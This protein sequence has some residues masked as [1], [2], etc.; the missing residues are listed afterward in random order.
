MDQKTSGNSTLSN[1]RMRINSEPTFEEPYIHNSFEGNFQVSMNSSFQIPHIQVERSPRDEVFPGLDS[2]PTSAQVLP[3]LHDDQVQGEY[4]TVLDMQTFPSDPIYDDA[5]GSAFPEYLE[6]IPD[7]PN[8]RQNVFSSNQTPGAQD[9]P[10]QQETPE[11]ENI[12]Q[13]LKDND[14]SEDGLL[15]RNVQSAVNELIETEENYVQWLSFLTADVQDSLNQ[16]PQ[17]DVKCLFSNLNEIVVLSSSFL[18]ELKKTENDKENQLRHIGK[19]FQAFSQDMQ[20]SYSFYCLNYPGILSLLRQYK[21][22]AVLPQIQKVLQSKARSSKMLE[23]SFLLVK[24]VQRITKYPLLIERMLKDV[25]S[26]HKSHEE[27]QKALNAM[28]DVNIN[29]N[30]NKRCRE[31]AS[32]YLHEDERSLRDRVAQINS[33]SLLKKSRRVGTMLKQEAGILPKREDKEFDTLVE[34]FQALTSIVNELKENILCYMKNTEVLMRFQLYATEQEFLQGPAQ[35]FQRLSLLLFHKIYPEFIRRLQI[36][37]LQPLENLSECLKGPKNLIRKHMDKLLD[38]ENLENKGSETGNVSY[39]EEQII[40]TYKTIHS[41]LLCELPRC[42]TLSYQWLHKILLNFCSLQ[43]ELAE[44]GLHAADIEAAQLP[45]YKAP[46]TEFMR[47]IEDS[48]KQFSSQLIDIC[49]KFD[50]QI[51]APSVQDQNPQFQHQVHILV[52]HHGHEKIYQLTSNISGSRDLDLTL[53]RGQV[54]AVLQMSDTK[55]NKNRWL[56]DTGGARGYVPSSKLQAYHVA[57]H[58]HPG[59]RLLA[60]NNITEKRRHSYTSQVCP[61]PSLQDTT[62]IF[63]IVAGYPYTA[64]SNYEVTVMGGEPVTVL[65][66]HDKKGSP[67]WSLVEVNGQR[68]YIPSNYLMKVPVQKK[69]PSTTLSYNM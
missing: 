56:V 14:V 28:L 3:N 4:E 61:Y 41:M 52:Q 58:P 48:I 10:C 51:P 37:V 67:E 15:S 21:E 47:W 62:P 18:E 43:R 31:V 45:Y 57:N 42:T 27:L 1:S 35:Q 33:H 36:L 49:K 11:E 50:E 16:I 63:Q 54:V 12:Y 69:I 30:D 66:P 59:N 53:Q 64:R 19:L 13:T 60:V 23:L 22:T 25:P 32:K 40:N 5:E 17:V 9:T 6:L 29:I 8:L 38:F 34:N 65:E 39:E 26:N 20:S 24:P 7:S 55:G 2:P 44:Q 46:K 68:G